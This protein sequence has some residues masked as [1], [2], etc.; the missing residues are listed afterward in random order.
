MKTIFLVDDN[1][2]NLNIVEEVL[3]GCYRVDCFPCAAQLF[4]AL[5]TSKPHMILL[6]VDMPVMS[7]FEAMTILRGNPSYA[8]I[9][10]IF[11]TGRT[12]PESEAAGIELGAADFIMKPF[13]APVLLNR[14]QHHL[15]VDEMIRQ[16]T[17]MLTNLKN[18]LVFTMADLV[19]NRDRDT[20]GHIERTSKN[21]ELLIVAMLE[22]K[23][24]ADE[25]RTWDVDSVVSSA[26]L[27]DVGKIVISDTILNK[28]GPLTQ[29]EFETM[30]THTL[31][32]ERIIDGVIRLAGASDFLHDAKTIAASHHE[33]WNGTGYPHGL[34]GREIPL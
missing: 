8:S 3:K 26:R 11:L 18:A 29:S 16:R 9:P 14:I 6:D 13:S 1:E 17:K 27:H 5:E 31:E 25:M 7:G 12:D 2:T 23:I 19:E 4:S 33:R 30:K 21:L 24:Y 28:T 20:I 34:K 10:V 15:H 32:G 22:K